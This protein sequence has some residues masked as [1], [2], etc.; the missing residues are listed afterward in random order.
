MGTRHLLIA[1]LSVWLLLAAGPAD[2]KICTVLAV[3]SYEADFPWTAEIMAG[4]H[5]ALDGRCRVEAFYLNTKTDFAGGAARAREAYARYEALAP[6]GVIAADDDAQTLFVVPY[7]AGKVATPV[8]FCG[9]NATPAAYGYPAANVSGILERA[10]VAETIALARQLVPSIRTV[11][12]ILK[13]TP[14][15]RAFLAQVEAE[16]DSYPARIAGTYLPTTLDQALAMTAEAKRAADLLYVE[17]LEGLPDGKGRALGDREVIPRL[18]AAFGKATAGANDYAVRDGLLCAVVKSGREQGET[19]A[20]MLLAAM[21][22]TPISALPPVRN[23]LGRQVIN[24]TVLRALGITP[25]PIVLR[26]A[27]L[28]RTQVWEK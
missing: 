28:V 9:V 17:T 11:A 21:S 3:M 27:E 15:A 10:H 4:I 23:R 19:A 25:R 7:L 5:A 2:G 16:K 6:Q 18:A 1:A 26:G 20:R 14:A 13:D 8:M 22:G 12:F 24:V